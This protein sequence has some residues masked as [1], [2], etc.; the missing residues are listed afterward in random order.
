MRSDSNIERLEAAGHE[1]CRNIFPFRVT[2]SDVYIKAFSDYG[3]RYFLCKNNSVLNL[4]VLQART[5]S[6]SKVLQFNPRRIVACW[7]RSNSLS[8]FVHGT[9]YR[10]L[11]C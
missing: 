4:S 10:I 11:M 3:K 7:R 9:A 2:F 1:Y 8:P 5:A 6:S